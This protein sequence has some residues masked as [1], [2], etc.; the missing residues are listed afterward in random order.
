MKHK[1]FS[2][3]NQRIKGD[4]NIAHYVIEKTPKFFDWLVTLLKEALDV[5]NAENL[6]KFSTFEDYDILPR[7]KKL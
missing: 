4:N 5:E 3:G 1:L 7:Q 6:V 2:T